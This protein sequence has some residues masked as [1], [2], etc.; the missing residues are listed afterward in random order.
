MY[1]WLI[2]TLIELDSYN[3]KYKSNTNKNDKSIYMININI[4]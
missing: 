1:I 3:K 4:K 2:Y